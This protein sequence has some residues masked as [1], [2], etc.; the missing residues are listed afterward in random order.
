MISNH[1]NLQHI[2]CTSAKDWT[3]QHASQKKLHIKNT[4]ANTSS[5]CNHN[6]HVTSLHVF[7]NAYQLM[8]FVFFG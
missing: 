2:Q 7:C 8:T 5:Y 1:F 3:S 6:I 4:H